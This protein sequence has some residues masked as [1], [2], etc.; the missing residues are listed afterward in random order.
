MLPVYRVRDGWNT[1]S[2]NNAIFENCSEILSN[3]EAIVIFPEGSH[4]LAR[5][6]RPLSKGFTR[7]VFDTLEKYPDLDLHLI[8]IGLNFVKA[9]NCPDSAAMYF[10]K[11]LTVKDFIKDNKNEGV[12]KLKE[13]VHNKIKNLTTHIPEKNYEEDLQKLNNF[14]VDFLKPNEVN[15]CLK[16]NFKKCKTRPRSKTQFLSKFFQLLLKI[17]LIVPYIIW[18]FIVQPK[19]KEIEFVS[20]FRFAIAIT[21][22]PFYLVIVT[23]VISYIFSAFTGLVYLIISMIIA[24]F[25]I[26]F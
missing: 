12:V 25:A 22:V 9:E 15:S 21:L 5:R 26:K 18:K 8:P 3:K 20:T 10:G 23:I 2:N 6:V 7:I 11:S 4:N 19:I 13:A 16:S 24:L 14:N 1:I 17:N